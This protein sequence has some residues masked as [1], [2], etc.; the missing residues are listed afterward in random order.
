MSNLHNFLRDIR[1]FFWIIIAIGLLLFLIH[2]IENY[3]I[4]STTEPQLVTARGEL[5]NS[6]KSN[7]E[8]FRQA[9]PSVVYITTLT[10]M[11]NLWTRDI[12]RIPRG[13]GSG[14]VWDKHGHIITNYHVLQGATE[15]RI[16]LSDHRTFNAVLI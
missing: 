4:R 8:I 5:S 15:I 1:L 9:S 6:E 14:F 7:I 13:T 10:E 2:R 16:G 12:T 3:L 11:V